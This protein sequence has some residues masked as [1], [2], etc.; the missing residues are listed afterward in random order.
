M[1]KRTIIILLVLLLILVI[2]SIVCFGI[3]KI[4]L[5]TVI[6][7]SAIDWYDFT[8][9]EM[10][11][12][13][14]IIALCTVEDLKRVGDMKIEEQP[15]GTKNKVVSSHYEAKFKVK[16][17]YKGKLTGNTISSRTQ[18]ND[19]DEYGIIAVDKDNGTLTEYVIMF[20]YD[21]IYNA[22]IT[23]GGG[24]SV[25]KY[26]Q[27]TNIYENGKG[28]YFNSIQEEIQNLQNIAK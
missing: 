2:S 27:E 4:H 10:I 18:G 12:E 26:N 6:D 9:E 7:H 5:P 20:R 15:D 14:D 22:Y 21:D 8:L 13:S 19:V 11:N 17:I 1:S 25:F 3:F 24:Q 16:E 23:L 28:E